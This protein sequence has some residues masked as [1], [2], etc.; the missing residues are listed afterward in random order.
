MQRREFLQLSSLALLGLLGVSCNAGDEVV[1]TKQLNN[2]KSGDESVIVIGSGFSGLAAARTLHD[3]G[4]QVTVLEARDR[5]GGRVWTRDDLGFGLDMGASW[6]HGINGN[7]ITNL[8]E[9]NDLALTIPTNSSSLRVY[10]IDGHAIGFLKLARAF[11][12]YNNDMS[13]LD[14]LASN[15]TVDQSVYETLN[16]LGPLDDLPEDRRRLLNFM[17]YSE[18]HQDLSVSPSQKNSWCQIGYSHHLHVVPT[19]IMALDPAKQ[20]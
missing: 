12:R 11:L 8:A 5:I 19:Q 6:I 20:I 17:Y 3:F 10:D 9:A 14:E 15:L 4:Y 16:E 13:A 2:C 1:E 7:P 18:F